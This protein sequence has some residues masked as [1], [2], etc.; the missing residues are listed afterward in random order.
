MIPATKTFVFALKM[1]VSGR[2]P[3]TG[4]FLTHVSTVV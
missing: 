1:T 3:P 2:R 4:H